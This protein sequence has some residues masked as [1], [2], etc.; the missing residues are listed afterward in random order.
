VKREI[1][2]IEDQGDL[3]IFKEWLEK[4][5]AGETQTISIEELEQEL[6][7]DGLLPG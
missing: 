7:E 4:R 3:A 2:L 1:E 5:A 6:T